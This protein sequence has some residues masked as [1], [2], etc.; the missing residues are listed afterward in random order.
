MAV[1]RM[2]EFLSAVESAKSGKSGGMVVPHRPPR[3]TLGATGSDRAQF[4]AG[5][6][7]SPCRCYV[8]LFR[9][10]ACMCAVL[11]CW[12]V[13]CVLCGGGGVELRRRTLCL[14]TVFGVG[15][16][17]LPRCSCSVARVAAALAVSLWF[18]LC[19]SLCC[20]PPVPV[21]SLCLCGF[22]LPLPLSLCLPSRSPTFPRPWCTFPPAVGAVGRAIHET[23]VKLTEMTKRQSRGLVASA[24]P[25][26]SPCSP[27]RTQW[28]NTGRCSATNPTASTS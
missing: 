15:V 10:W 6:F 22:V 1:D 19:V 18:L 28:S 8:C 26:G 2:A 9:L 17:F 14:E 27:T 13:S 3:P 12:D 25:R 4:T 11:W 21:S 23:S 16:T 7:S 5:A 20:C 24:C